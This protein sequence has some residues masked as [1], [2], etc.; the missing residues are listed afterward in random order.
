[1]NP[2]SLK[3][4]VQVDLEATLLTEMRIDQSE[5]VPPSDLEDFLNE[6]GSFECIACGACCED[7]RWC[8]PSWQVEGATRCKHLLE[9]KQ[10]AIYEDRPWVCRMD[11]FQGWEMR[12][13]DVAWGCSFMRNKFYGSTKEPS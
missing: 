7:V 1:M 13:R 12:A 11:S 10:C 8:L 6:K 4:P 3:D 5:G 2:S 9:D